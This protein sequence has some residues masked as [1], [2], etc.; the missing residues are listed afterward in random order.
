MAALRRPGSAA[1]TLTGRP[2]RDATPSTRIYEFASA[3]Y[4]KTGGATADLRRVY[5]AYLENQKKPPH[6]D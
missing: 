1:P 3:A 6:K 2:T 5:S 4:K